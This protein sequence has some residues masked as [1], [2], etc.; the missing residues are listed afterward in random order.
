L[1]GY[2]RDN[3][4]DPSNLTVKELFTLRKSLQTGTCSFKQ[5]PGADKKAL[6]LIVN[7]QERNGENPWGKRKRRNVV[8]KPK[9]KKKI[10]ESTVH[11]GST[12]PHQPPSS[13]G[14]Q[15]EE[16]MNS[17][18]QSDSDSDDT[19]DSII[20][21]ENRIGWPRKMIH[22]HTPKVA[23]PVVRGNTSTSSRS[24]TNM[25]VARCS[26][27]IY[28]SASASSDA[29]MAGPATRPVSITPSTTPST[30]VNA[31]TTAERTKE[32]HSGCIEG[33][34]LFPNVLPA[35]R[36]IDHDDDLESGEDEI[37]WD[38]HLARCI[39]S[40]GDSLVY[41]DFDT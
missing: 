19:S 30:G 24:L 1:V 8:D 38:T 2:P 15:I 26:S 25:K 12:D 28:T 40:L 33:S 7:E 39:K 3:I 4:C 20:R 31:M 18:V 21:P 27:S 13:L 14:H 9:K 11:L 34:G 37:E 23:N 36:S 5:L 22:K 6:E 32:L 17:M 41:H 35:H 10:S 29:H 16:D